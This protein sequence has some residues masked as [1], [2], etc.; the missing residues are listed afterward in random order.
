MIIATPSQEQRL[1]SLKVFPGARP[2]ACINPFDPHQGPHAPPVLQV[3]KRLAVSDAAQV[4]WGLPRVAGGSLSLAHSHLRLPVGTSLQGRWSPPCGGGRPHI[5]HSFR[6]SLTLLSW[7]LRPFMGGLGGQR[8]PFYPSFL[9][10]Y[11]LP[12]RFGFLHSPLLV[13]APP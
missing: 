10:S 7:L 6:E 3:R 13:L 1:L 2:C 11:S 4:W 9:L 8:W 12:F 5:L